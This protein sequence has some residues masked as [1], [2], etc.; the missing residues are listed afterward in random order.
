MFREVVVAPLNLSV[1]LLGLRQ[2]KK[3]AGNIGFVK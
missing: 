1:I 3:W 2:R